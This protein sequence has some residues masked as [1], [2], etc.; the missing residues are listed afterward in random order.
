[1][2][3]SNPRS[4]TEDDRALETPPSNKGVYFSDKKPIVAGTM[5]GGVQAVGLAILLVVLD[6]FI[7]GTIPIPDAV[8]V[9]A[10]ML[11]AIARIIEASIDQR[12]VV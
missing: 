6:Q 8:K 1:M 11:Y 10:P 5:R 7:G 9:Y 4:V 12:Q 3:N 2:N